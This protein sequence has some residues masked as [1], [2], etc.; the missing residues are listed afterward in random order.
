MRAA[1]D[2]TE[3]RGTVGPRATAANDTMPVRATLTSA[4][5]VSATAESSS[6]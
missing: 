6:T 1:F 4:T 5:P 3:G 2:E